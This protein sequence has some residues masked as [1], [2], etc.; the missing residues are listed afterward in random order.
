MTW[1]QT[2]TGVRFDLLDP[3]PGMVSLTDIAVSLSRQARYNGHTRHP[4]SVAQH[5]CLVADISEILGKE[6]TTRW[7]F[8]AHGLMHD[9]AEAYIGD[10]VTPFKRCW[11]IDARAEI[12]AIEHS[13]HKAIAQRFGLEWEVPPLVYQADRI[14]LQIEKRDIVKDFGLD[15]GLPTM[16]LLAWKDCR[17]RAAGP[18]EAYEDFLMYAYELEVK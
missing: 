17:I 16:D 6:S 4:Y 1:V 5:S 13:I 3:K 7:S 18:Q 8:G 10:I 9:A 15:W 11:T 2:Y 12:V 14:A